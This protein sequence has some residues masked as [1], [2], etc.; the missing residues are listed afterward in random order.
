VSIARS[1]ARPIASRIASRTTIIGGGSPTIQGTF[2][3]SD[4]SPNLGDTVTLT[5]TPTYTPA[6]TLTFVFRRGSTE[7]GTTNPLA[8]TDWEVGDDGQY[9]VDV[10][11]PGL[12][13]SR[14]FGP[15]SVFAIV[16]PVEADFFVSDETPEIDDDVTFT[17][18]IRT[19]GSFDVQLTLDGDPVSGAT[20]SP[21]TV[22]G[23]QLANN[24]FYRLEITDTV[25]SAVTIIGPIEVSSAGPTPIAVAIVT[26]PSNRSVVEGQNAVYSVGFTGSSPVTIQWRENDGGGPV[27]ISGATSSVLTLTSVDISKNGYTYDVV[28]TNLVNSVT[29][30]SASLEVTAAPPP[31]VDLDPG[32]WEVAYSDTVATVAADDTEATGVPYGLTAT[33]SG[34]VLTVSGTPT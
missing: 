1:I 15:I 7:V 28:L 9:F 33:V 21:F 12:S 29:S 17:W 27:N 13:T 18:D 16:D 3:V 5:F 23:W 30:D 24:G 25:T 6:G 4:S 26:Q 10:T 11:D 22:S 31:G 14:T 34:G 8:I 32:T 2:S 19:A 20:S